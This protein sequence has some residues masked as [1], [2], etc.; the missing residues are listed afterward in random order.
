MELHQDLGGGQ[1][2][3][4]PFCGDP[5]HSLVHAVID[6]DEAQLHEPLLE[7]DHAGGAVVVV[8]QQSQQ[9]LQSHMEGILFKALQDSRPAAPE[10]HPTV[11]QAVEQIAA[12]LP[13]LMHYYHQKAE[14][15]QSEMLWQ[16]KIDAVVGDR[17]NEACLAMECHRHGLTSRE[18][19]Q[20]RRE[21]LSA[22]GLGEGRGREEAEK[23]EE[24]VGSYAKAHLEEF[25]NMIGPAVESAI[26]DSGRG[27]SL[28]VRIKRRV[29]EASRSRLLLE[30]FDV[31]SSSLGDA[32]RYS[33]CKPHELKMLSLQ[34]ASGASSQMVQGAKELVA[35]F[36]EAEQELGLEVLDFLGSKNV[37]DDVLERVATKL[38]GFPGKMRFLG[39]ANTGVSIEGLETLLHAVF[40]APEQVLHD[41]H[42]TYLQV[43]VASNFWAWNA[44]LGV[45]DKRW[46]YFK[47]AVKEAQSL[48]QSIHYRVLERRK[49]KHKSQPNYILEIFKGYRRNIRGREIPRLVLK[50]SADRKESF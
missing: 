18:Y 22:R 50:V 5:W 30:D 23:K 31:D 46:E 47:A 1:L 24:L 4:Q 49:R 9:P 43:Q 7:S 27:E 15:R 34:N 16:K 42:A 41:R 2:V 37:G 48:D 39:L 32:L 8:S 20:L 17:I 6:H 29:Q 28:R 26:F 35:W 14:Q 12:Q 36:S 19:D 13:D 45:R 3:M 21:L 10:V 11:R 40:K 38:P 25:Q 44:K 33:S